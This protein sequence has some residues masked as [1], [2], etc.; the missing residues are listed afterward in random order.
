[1]AEL[2]FECDANQGFNFKQDEHQTFGFITSLVIGEASMSP[3]F[4]VADPE[5]LAAIKP[6]KAGGLTGD[7]EVSTSSKFTNP[8]VA[9]LTAVKWPT[10]ATDKI[11]FEGRVSST[12]MQLIQNLI[13]QSMPKMVVRIAFI[14]Y[15]YDPNL[16]A[17]YPAFKTYQGTAPL[18]IKP[19][20]SSGGFGANSSVPEVYGILSKDGGA[21]NL[22]ANIKPEDEPVGFI[23]FGFTM[24]VAATA[25]SDVQQLQV[26]TSSV[27]KMIKPW[28]LPRN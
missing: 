22:T 12:N 19:G 10:N 24:A 13:L 6:K 18:G 11:E 17:Y 16:Q 25:A 4:K 28:G 15:V 1:M 23:N 27:A 26:Q 2:S 5:A 20:D 14:V 7:V 9:V 21:F 8:A 3:D